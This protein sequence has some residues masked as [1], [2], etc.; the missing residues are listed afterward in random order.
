MYAVT[1]SSPAGVK[2]GSVEIND[3]AII[4]LLRS[5][6]VNAADN[7]EIT[8]DENGTT[9]YVVVTVKDT[10]ALTAGKTYTLPLLIKAEGQA[11]NTAAS[12]LNLNLKVMK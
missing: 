9:V 8:L 6:L 1:L 5:S 10:S 3:S 4:G 2:L 12:K 11:E 7:I